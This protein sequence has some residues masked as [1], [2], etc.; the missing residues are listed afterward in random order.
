MVYKT[1]ESIF[2]DVLEIVELL[3]A[4]L[5]NGDA[6]KLI[7]DGGL[8]VKIEPDLEC[9]ILNDDCLEFFSRD[10]TGNELTQGRILLKRIVG[11][12]VDV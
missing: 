2:Q 11:V 6:A 12:L 3:E 4:I 10:D 8:A 9:R 7:L 5:K 1:K